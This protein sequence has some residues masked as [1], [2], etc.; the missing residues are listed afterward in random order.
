MT[1]SIASRLSVLAFVAL[2]AGCAVTG[3]PAAEPTTATGEA[4][5]EQLSITSP[6][7]CAALAVYE[8]ATVDDWGLRAGIA[9][10]ALNGFATAG[11]VPDCAEGVAAALTGG[12]FSPNRWQNALDAV[13]A[14]DAGDYALPD[15]C[16]RANAVIPANAPGA[17]AASFPMAAQAQCVMHG[18]AFVEVQP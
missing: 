8:L 18:L 9:R 17:L 11:R 12:E 14:V 3:Q 13:D 7:F 10:A 6:R 15:A 5:P 4:I 2:A 1:S 16:A